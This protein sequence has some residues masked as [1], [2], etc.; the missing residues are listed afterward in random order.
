MRVD[1]TNFGLYWENETYKLNRSIVLEWLND[2]WTHAG[3]DFVKHVLCQ[4]LSKVD[5][6]FVFSYPLS[7]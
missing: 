6:N 7:I 3:K 1:T 4:K 5:T 2:T